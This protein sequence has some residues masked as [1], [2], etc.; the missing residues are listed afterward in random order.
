[1]CIIVPQ[2]VPGT[3]QPLGVIVLKARGAFTKAY[4]YW[5]GVVVMIGYTLLFNYLIYLGLAYLKREYT[6]LHP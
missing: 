3:N 5:I 1:M 2:I 4:W 6:S